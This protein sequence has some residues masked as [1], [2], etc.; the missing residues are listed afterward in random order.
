MKVKICGITREEDA[1]T[2]VDAGADAL[3]FIFSGKSPR[4]I[5]LAAARH[6]IAQLPP[7]VS[8]VGVFVDVPRAE[9]LETIRHTG[10][11]VVQLHGNEMPRDLYDI[12][13][14][15]IKA[16]RIGRS[17]DVRTLGAYSAGAYLLDTYLPGTPGGTGKTFDW[18]IAVKAK[19]FGPVILSG[20][21]TPAN[22]AEAARRVRPFAIDISS[23]VESSP[24]I[25]DPEKIRHLFN[26]VRSVNA[27][28]DET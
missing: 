2:V 22:V 18:G 28:S 10:I 20:G 5:S 6:I 4:Q 13:V 14:P 21:I 3:G 27:D 11:H 15:V 17:F 24:G 19:A 9:I 23:G 7:F 16:F 12:P 8:A 25:K 1:L 26:V